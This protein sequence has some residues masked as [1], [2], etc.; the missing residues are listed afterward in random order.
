MAQEPPRSEPGRQPV[1]RDQLLDLDPRPDQRPVGAIHQ[2]F[3]HQG[4]RIVG[5][6]LH[7][8]LGAGRHHGQKAA[9]GGLGQ[10]TI[11]CEEIPALAD[12][13]DHIGDDAASVARRLLHRQ[14]GVI[15]LV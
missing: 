12:R 14:D 15:G 3:R 6:G 5:A 1:E 8:A 9:R 7:R 13:A 11:F 2:H 4:A 10:I